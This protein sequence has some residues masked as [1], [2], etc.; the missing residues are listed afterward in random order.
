M[1]KFIIIAEVM[2]TDKEAKKIYK[3][4]KVIWD[5]NKTIATIFNKPIKFVS[6]TVEK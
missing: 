3:I 1:K 2:I 6:A 5:T 4:G